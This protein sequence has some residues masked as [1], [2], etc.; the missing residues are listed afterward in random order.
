MYRE[1]EFWSQLRCALGFVLNIT[2]GYLSPLRNGMGQ[3]VVRMEVFK[4][5]PI[6]SAGQFE[7]GSTELGWGEVGLGVGSLYPSH[8]VLCRLFSPSLGSDAKAFCHKMKVTQC[9][10][11]KREIRGLNKPVGNYWII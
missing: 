6:L 5:R 10:Q 1:Q 8:L 11:R 7:R 3:E 2:E 9:T 4:G